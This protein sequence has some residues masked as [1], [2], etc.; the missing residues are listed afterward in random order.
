MSPDDETLVRD[1]L[2]GNERAFETLLERYERKVFN[3]ALRMLNNRDDAKD[4]T[5]AVFLKVYENLGRFD[6]RYKFFSWIYRIM[7][8]ESI[9]LIRRRKPADPIDEALP[10]M[11]LSPLDSLRGAELGEAIQEA[12]MSLKPDYRSVI[13]LRH[14]HDCSYQEMSRILEIREET[15]KSRLFSARRILRDRILRKGVH[16]S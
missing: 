13:I 11:Q 15:V 5:Q 6:P 12:L 2:D 1:C 3:G 16:A 7:V 9:N 10:A 8:N 14:F 4:I